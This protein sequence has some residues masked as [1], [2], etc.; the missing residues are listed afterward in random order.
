[1]THSSAPQ[2]LT[3]TG[4][5]TIAYHQSTVS[6]SP[7][8]GVIF[9]G[10]FKSDMEGSKALFLEKFCASHNVNYL[11][12]DY[13]GHGKSSGRFTDG[14]IGRWEQ[15]AITVFDQLTKGKYIIVGSSMGGWIMLLTALQRTER[16]TGMIGIAAAPDFTETLIWDALDPDAKASLER[17]GFYHLP[18]DYC[19]D[20][21]EESE[22]Y[23]ITHQLITEARS[24]LLLKGKN[25]IAID[26]PVRLLHGMKDEDVPYQTSIELSDAIRSDDVKTTFVK[27]GDHRMSSEENLQLLEQTLRELLDHVRDK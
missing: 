6:S 18:S 4:G 13:S 8:P 22:P 27:N 14:T 5:D 11:R 26:C 2:I 17:D 10:G 3:L 15:D 1:M 12:F 25:S 24:H 23:T 16:I 19:N 7:Y 20:P 9:M 21:A